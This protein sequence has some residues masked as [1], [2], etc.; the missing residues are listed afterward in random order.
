MFMVQWM[1]RRTTTFP[2][3]SLNEHRISTGWWSLADKACTAFLR[4]LETSTLAG[5]LTLGYS[6]GRLQPVALALTRASIA[7]SAIATYTES[8]HSKPKPST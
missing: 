4:G 1:P 2:S 8:R 7:S 6:K 5:N 3:W